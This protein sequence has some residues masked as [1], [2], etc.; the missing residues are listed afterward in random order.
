MAELPQDRLATTDASGGRVYLYPADVTG[1]YRSLRVRLR[2]MLVW[3]FLLV[4]WIQWN[5]RQIVHLDVA[6]RKFVLFGFQFWAHDVPMA[7]LLILSFALAIA[8]VTAVWGRLWC[9]WACPQTVFVEGVYRRVERWIEGP[10]RTRRA[11]DEGPLSAEKL[12]RKALKYGAF[13]A[14]SLVVAH[15]FLAYF[16]GSRE[17]L[18]MIRRS[19]AEN[20]TP[21]LVILFT[22]ALVMFDFGWFREQFC[23]IMCPYGRFQSVLMDESSMIVGYDEKRGEPRRGRAVGPQGDCVN[24]LRCV[25]VCPT[26]IDIR[27]GV[28]MECIACTAC[29]D[30]CDEVM[31][32]VKKPRGLIAYTTLKSLGGETSSTW[33]P[34]TLAYSL[35]LLSAV[36]ALALAL[37]QK[38]PLEVTLLRAKETP[39]Q[40]ATDAAGA[41]VVIN[42]FRVD[43]ANQTNGETTVEFTL[44]EGD[45][46][47]GFEIIVAQ[48]PQTIPAST[49]RKIDVF[50]RFPLL[51]LAA[52]RA[53]GHLEVRSPL[54]Q[55]K[56]T[57]E[58][59]LV[60]PD[61]R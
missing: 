61:G 10:P 8:L 25:Q 27:R 5:G 2:A 3:I 38:E 51:A 4:P 12:L 7:F 48:N 1:R 36:L 53:R 20:W 40:Q 31:D 29:I 32:T 39:Y 49:H 14:V 58:A 46:A 57:L 59:A 56:K 54:L 44:A 22:T 34:R 33:R 15:S 17:L 37:R 55:E 23:V 26:G 13:T 50:F 18:E 47:R 19:P 45:R 30:A 28:Q 42:H 21:F 52:G 9:G 35:L 60:G 6:N 11:R 41:P 24:C 43:V 16:V